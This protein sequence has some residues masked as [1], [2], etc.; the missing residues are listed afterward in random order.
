MTR[1]SA[2]KSI[3]T[4]AGI[5]VEEDHVFH[6]HSHGND[7]PSSACLREPTATTSPLEGFSLAVSGMYRPLAVGPRIRGA[8]QEHS[9]SKVSNS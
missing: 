5:L 6:L 1:C 2:P 9:H 4:G 7:L 3:L 8:S